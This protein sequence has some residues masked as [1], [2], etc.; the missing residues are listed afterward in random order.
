[1]ILAAYHVDELLSLFESVDNQLDLAEH[2]ASLSRPPAYGGEQWDLRNT[3]IRIAC[4]VAIQHEADEH[5]SGVLKHACTERADYHFYRRARRAVHLLRDSG[6]EKDAVNRYVG[7]IDPDESPDSLEFQVQADGVIT[8]STISQDGAETR[9]KEGAQEE[10]A[11][12]IGESRLRLLNLNDEEASEKTSDVPAE[13]DVSSEGAESFESA[14]L[15]EGDDIQFGGEEAD[16]GRDFSVEE[17]EDLEDGSSFDEWAM[18]EDVHYDREAHVYLYYSDK[19][20]KMVRVPGDVIQ[21]MKADYSNQEGRYLT[22]NQMARK[23]ELARAYVIELKKKFGWTHDSSIYTAE[24][25][26]EWDTE[27]LDRRAVETRERKA[28]HRAQSLRDRDL[29]KKAEKWE[30]FEV[31]ILEPITRAIHT[32]RPPEAN[33]RPVNAGLMMSEIYSAVVNLVD[34]HFG[35]YGWALQM[36]GEGYSRKEARQ[37]VIEKTLEIADRLAAYEIDKLFLPGGSDLFHVNTR[38]HLTNRGTPQD[39]DGTYVQMVLEGC[40][41]FVDVIEILRQVCKEL[42]LIWVAGNHD[43]DASLSPMLYAKGRYDADPE[44][45]NLADVESHENPL[46][47][48]QSVTGG[49][50]DVRVELCPAERQYVVWKNNLLGFAH[51]DGPKMKR[52]PDIMNVEAGP[53]SKDALNH[54]WFTGHLHHDRLVDLHGTYIIQSPSLSGSDRWHYKKG[55][56]GSRRSM[57]A[58]LI[59]PEKGLWNHIPSPVARPEATNVLNLAA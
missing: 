51:G 14:G 15:P 6:V 33:I 40:S 54:M 22:I 23:Y 10:P 52:L 1:M 11:P 48:I 3:V 21:E 20:K 47:Q 36:G 16:E 38:Q 56:V 49:A 39:M 18:P 17:D 34:L 50:S 43:G 2:T 42:V 28:L 12:S 13:S 57:D 35:K 53:V 8:I 7:V 58:Y 41:M 46:R 32:Y 9:R 4:A 59:H 26:V 27:Q 25:L 30:N 37:L 55:F 44:N 45:I 19:A 5:H 31:H 24:E 29:K